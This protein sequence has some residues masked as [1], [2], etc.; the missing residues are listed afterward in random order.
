[1]PQYPQSFVPAPWLSGAHLQTIWSPLFRRQKLRGQKLPDRTREKMLLPDGDFI[2]L[3]WLGSQDSDKPLTVLL[4]G[5]TGCSQSKYIVGL[6]RVLAN[7]GFPS[8]AMNFRGCGGEPNN[9]TV[10][11]HSGISGDL[12]LVLDIL[13]SRN[14]EQTL[15]AAGF[16]LGG[17][18]LLKYLGEQAEHS[19]LS[20]AVAVS[21]PFEL[22]QCSYRINEGLSRIY[23]DRFMRDMVGYLETK[24]QHFLKNGWSD[25]LKTLEELGSLDSLTTFHEYDGRVTAPLHGFNSAEDYY[26]RCSSRRFLGAITTPTLILQAAD[27]P[28]LFP[29]SVPDKSELSL[30][31]TMELTE[32]G[33]HVGF[34]SHDR[35][36]PVYWLESRIPAFL[37]FIASLENT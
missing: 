3:D 9:L 20:A 32:H 36:K 31:T 11:Y 26:Q 28:F 2:N 19:Q 18:V 15:M 23:R 34:I 14:P 22:G 6:Q 7:Q 5:L 33:G 1:M 13:K 4:H 17:N 10:G 30:S 16:S 12:K 8:V 21:V 37:S 24:K 25:R 29:H 27:D 35:L